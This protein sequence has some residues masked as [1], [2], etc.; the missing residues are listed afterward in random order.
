MSPPP[1]LQIHPRYALG[2]VTGGRYRIGF[3]RPGVIIDACDPA[4]YEVIQALS[5]GSTLSHVRR[6]AR[7]QG[8]GADECEQLVER[9]RPVLIRTPFPLRRGSVRVA[10]G[11]P[12]GTSGVAAPEASSGAPAPLATMTLIDSQ[13]M[14]R[15][16]TLR[17]PL[18]ASL[19][20]HGWSLRDDAAP[21][22]STVLVC[23]R[24]LPDP[25]LMRRLWDAGSRVIPVTFGDSRVVVGP[26]LAHAE[27]VCQGCWSAHETSLDPDWSALA[28]AMMGRASPC[29]SAAVMPALGFAVALLAGSAIPQQLRLDVWDGA[30]LSPPEQLPVLRCETCAYGETAFERDLALAGSRLIP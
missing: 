17:R 24:Y 12:A 5:R 21:A 19:A 27:R 14:L 10:A 20:A 11:A 3:D 1:L 30:V 6:V 22:P 16:A 23:A 13:G 18:A 9:L 28:T 25:R 8:L 7:G 15:D 29:V 26:L 2:W 4:R